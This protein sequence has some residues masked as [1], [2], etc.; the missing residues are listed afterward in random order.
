MDATVSGTPLRPDSYRPGNHAKISIPNPGHFPIELEK[1][2]ILACHPQG[3][4]C[5]I[6][7]ARMGN[8]TATIS[9]KE[10][11]EELPKP[12]ILY[13]DYVQKAAIEPG[14]RG[15]AHPGRKILAIRYHDA[16]HFLMNETLVIGADNHFLT[17]IAYDSG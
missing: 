2:A 13:Y 12:E 11:Y 4:A 5:E 1:D 9:A 17:P 15:N 6:V 3:T 7:D 8:M 10:I 16:Y 14:L